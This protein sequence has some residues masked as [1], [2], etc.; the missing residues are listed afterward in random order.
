MRPLAVAVVA[1][2]NDERIVVEPAAA[3]PVHDDPDMAVDQF[4]QPEVR[5]AVSPPPVGIVDLMLCGERGWMGRR[6]RTDGLR[7]ERTDFV[8]GRQHRAVGYLALLDPPKVGILLACPLA[9]VV[10]I[11]ERGDEEE[12]GASPALATIQEKLAA[13]DGHIGVEGIRK[14]F[15]PAYLLFF[16]QRQGAIAGVVAVVTG[17]RQDSSKRR[18]WILDLAIGERYFVRKRAGDDAVARRRARRSG[19]VRA[20]EARAIRGKAVHHRCRKLDIPCATHGIRR[21]L[22]REDEQD[23]RS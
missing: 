17:R 1:D 15:E 8:V 7:F 11:D 9:Y 2:E 19:A 3:K 5:A 14:R 18:F 4:D 12:W 16:A 10:G 22:V 13:V 23:V 20:L 21:L 6:K